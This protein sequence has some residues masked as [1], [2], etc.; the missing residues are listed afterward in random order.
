MA[1]SSKKAAASSK[2]I[3]CL[4]TGFDAFGGHRA[5]PTELMVETFPDIIKIGTPGHIRTVHISK[6]VLPTAGRRAW[7]KLKKALDE[8][9]AE[10]NRP[11]LVIMSGLAAR[12]TNIS[13]ER[14]AM[15]LRDYRIAD[16]DGHRPLDSPVD[17]KAPALLRTDTDLQAL[18]KTLERA[19]FAGE[20]SNHAGNF[21]C[22]E[23]YFQALNFALKNKQIKGTLFVH[24]PEPAAFI[25][26]A[27]AGK[28]KTV[29]KAA[30]EAASRH[31]RIK[32]MQRALLEIVESTAL[33]L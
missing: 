10:N 28:K 17:K 22:N 19:G 29:A 21:V 7:R 6:L 23:V 4:L 3:N 33:F 15:N 27:A 25:K 2:S 5:N 32:L 30:A 8:L 1:S 26:S 11:I 18:Q 9:A 31:E 24:W 14:Y 13:L 20:I 12:R 16:N